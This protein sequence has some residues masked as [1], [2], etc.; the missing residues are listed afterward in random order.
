MRLFQSFSLRLIHGDDWRSRYRKRTLGFKGLNATISH[1]TRVKLRRN[2]V[3]KTVTTDT[4]GR[5]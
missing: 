1:V 2:K 5:R 3:D 4:S